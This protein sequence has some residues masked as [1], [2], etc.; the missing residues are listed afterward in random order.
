MSKILLNET[1]RVSFLFQLFDS[2]N[3]R[4]A[5]SLPQLRCGSLPLIAEGGKVFRIEE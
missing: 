1:S 4:F 3:L 2:S 5:S